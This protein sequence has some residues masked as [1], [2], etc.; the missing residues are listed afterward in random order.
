M[1][2]RFTVKDLVLYA[3]L[4]L[5]FLTLLLTMYMIDRQWL[6]LAQV[7]RSV[8]EQAEDLRAMRTLLGD[9]DRRIASGAVAAVDSAGGVGVP[10]AFARAKAAAERPD[11]APGDWLVMAFG[12][13]L[14]TITPLI[15]TDAYA[16]EVQS[17]VLESLLIR[18]PQ[19]LEWQGL[20]ARDW[21]VSEDGLRFTFQLREGVTFSDGEPLTAEDVAFTFRFIMDP[22]IAA[23]RDRAYYEK[24]AEVRATG[25]YEVVF[26]FKEPYF[27]SLALAGGMPVLPEHFYAPFLE[28]PQEFNQSKGL[29]LGSGPYRLEDPRGWTPDLGFVELRR[30]PRYWGPVQPP[31][32]RI[33]WK[34]IANDSARLTT[35]RN[36]EIDAYGARPIE[37]KKLLADPQLA[38]RSRHMEYMS[39]VAGYSYIGWNQRRNGRPTRFADKRVRQAMTYLT[40]RA[41]I[42][43][44]IFLGYAEPAISPFSPR[45]RQHD[46]ALQPR[47]FDLSKAK[48]LLA[49]AGYAD[50]DGDG[51]LDGRDGRPF[52]FELV[53]FQDNEDT[54]RMVLLL[55]DLYARAGILLEPKPTEWSVMLD[56]LNRKDFDAITLGW[57]SGVETDIYQMLHSS[58]TVDGGDNFVNYK[59][60]EL[61]RLIEQ[62]R[63]TVDEEARMPLWQACERILYEDQPY[64]FLLR[65]KTL[66]FLDHRFR[67]LEVTRLGLNFTSVPVETYVPRPL[68]RYEN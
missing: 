19:T 61:D 38:E 6:K 2:Q 64:T 39:P 49:E 32:E 58:Q 22:R 18:D 56:L 51:V 43:Q 48:A 53:Y 35:F 23:P 8:A 27:N 28:R 52:R 46:P 45:S 65:R 10:P 54:K 17:Y 41:R 47:P 34:I 63:S 67:N 5:L 66:L 7:Q 24:L 37:Y 59:N 33:L 21:Q 50:R 36:G 26:T 25:P 20:L 31:Y 30:N 62:A 55:K 12:T 60:P 15:S 16:A 3:I 57:T 68:Q 1:Q 42:I 11:Y 40:D 29:L 44:D 13:G 4:A 14:K 9:L